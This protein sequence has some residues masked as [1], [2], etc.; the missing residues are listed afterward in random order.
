MQLPTETNLIRKLLMEEV[1]EISDRVGDFV[2][3][4]IEYL[5]NDKKKANLF[6]VVRENQRKM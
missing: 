3:E 1:E 5:S 4:A 2:V 6:L